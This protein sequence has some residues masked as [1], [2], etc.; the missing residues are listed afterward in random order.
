MQDEYN[1][2]FEA[3][4]R[5]LKMTTTVMYL[6]DADH[7]SPIYTFRRTP[8]R[9]TECSD[10]FF[11]D[12]ASLGCGKTRPTAARAIEELFSNHACTN[13]RSMRFPSREAQEADPSGDAAE[14]NATVRERA[15]R[16]NKIAPAA[17]PDVS[18][19]D[20][21]RMLNEARKVWEM[22]EVGLKRDKMRPSE[23][24][25]A[26]G[27]YR[28]MKMATDALASMVS[29]RLQEPAASFPAVPEYKGQV[30]TAIEAALERTFKDPVVSFVR[31]NTNVITMKVQGPELKSAIYR[32]TVTQEK[33]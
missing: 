22:M 14:A 31:R 29:E 11:A 20:A 9:V 33:L 3:G 7:S 15:L 16:E 18:A 19:A 8:V 28:Q 13:I 32:I 1:A 21:L 23:F 10:G 25:M 6:V 17:F 5:N 30:V 2:A 26:T 24:A 12:H 4:Q 27:H